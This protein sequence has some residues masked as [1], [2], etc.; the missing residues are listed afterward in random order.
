M[1]HL[2][3]EGQLGMGK[4]ELVDYMVKTRKCWKAGEPSNF[5]F[6]TLEEATQILWFEDYDPHKYTSHLSTILSLMDHKP[7]T[8]SK[9]GVRCEV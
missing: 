2:Y 3:I 7:V 9:K 5:L 8:V 6:G 4:T 1:N